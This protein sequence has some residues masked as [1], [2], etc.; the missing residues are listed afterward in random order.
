MYR[1]ETHR[2]LL[3]VELEDNAMIVLQPLVAIEVD[4]QEYLA[5]T[6]PGGEAE[7]VYFYRFVE[8]TET[9]IELRN[10]DSDDVLDIVISEFEKWLD[11]QLQ[12]QEQ[13]E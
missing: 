11:A 5:L 8:H 9:E 13:E 1:D 6:P 7:A 4:G 12:Q 10:I 3:H 2:G